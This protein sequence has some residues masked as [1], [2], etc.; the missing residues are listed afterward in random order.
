MGLGGDGIKMGSINSTNVWVWVSLA[1]TMADIDLQVRAT[2]GDGQG[3]VRG[4][5]G[6]VPARGE[7]ID[8]V[9]NGVRVKT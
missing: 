2:D 4:S 7:L 1:D 5:S 9:A 3:C 6:T 8:R